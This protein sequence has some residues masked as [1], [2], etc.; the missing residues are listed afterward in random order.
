MMQLLNLNRLY[1]FTTNGTIF[2]PLTAQYLNRYI[3]L[4]GTIFEPLNGTYY[5]AVPQTE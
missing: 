4:N 5:C 1:S 2:E 3:T